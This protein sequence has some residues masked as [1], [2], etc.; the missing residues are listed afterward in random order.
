MM[1]Q[2]AA[3]TKNRLLRRAT[4]YFFAGMAVLTLF[5]N[6]CRGSR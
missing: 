2:T 3:T 1:E 6:T 5:S 4:I